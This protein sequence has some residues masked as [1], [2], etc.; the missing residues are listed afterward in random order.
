MQPTLDKQSSEE[1]KKK[2][3]PD[4]GKYVKNVAETESEN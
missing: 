4:Q 1:G 3:K 2:L